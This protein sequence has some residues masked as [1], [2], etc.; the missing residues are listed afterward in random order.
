MKRTND[1]IT[2]LADGLRV[3]PEAITR[4]L[5]NR[6]SLHKKL[7]YLLNELNRLIDAEDDTPQISDEHAGQLKARFAEFRAMRGCT[8]DNVFG[9]NL[10][11]S[12]HGATK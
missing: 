4:A 7:D 10:S 1:L 5:A 2:Q 8:C 11:C 12:Q 3:P 9:V 6:T